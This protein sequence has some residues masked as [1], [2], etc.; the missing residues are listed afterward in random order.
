MLSIGFYTL[1]EGGGSTANAL[2]AASYIADGGNGA[3]VVLAEPKMASRPVFRNIDA[4]DRYRDG[5]TIFPDWEPGADIGDADVVIYDYGMVGTGFHFPDLDRIFMCSDS[6]DESIELLEGYK[7]DGCSGQYTL[8]LK[9][10]CPHEQ[11]RKF[12]EKHS[13]TYVVEPKT[14]T[15]PIV[16]KELLDMLL[17]Q[18]G[19]KRPGGN[20][21]ICTDDWDM[22]YHETEEETAAQ[23][24]SSSGIF[25]VL[26]Q[27]ASVLT[28]LVKKKNQE[29]PIPKE[30][31]QQDQEKT[32]FMGKLF[33]K[34]KDG[35]TAA[36][37]KTPEKAK[38]LPAAIPEDKDSG[39]ADG[40]TLDDKAAEAKLTKEEKEE[41]ARLAAEKKAEAERLK[42][43]RAE[44]A[45]AEAAEKKRLAEE[46]KKRAKEGANWKK[47]L[48]QMD[49][50]KAQQQAKAEEEQRKKEAERL[51][52]EEAEQRKAA[53]LEKQRLAEEKQAQLEE[54]KKLSEQQKAEDAA[55]RAEELRLKKE[56]LEAARAAE[57]AKKALEEEDRRRKRE[58][59]QAEKARQAEEARL[60]REEAARKAAE[61]AAEKK[62]ARE[63]E[64]ERK[65]AEAAEKKAQAELKKKEE[66]ERRIRLIEEK[67]AEAAARQAELD[68]QREAEAAEKAA[69]EEAER[70][71]IELK[72]MEDEARRKEELEQ[73]KAEAEAKRREDIERKRREAEAAAAVK[74]AERE[75]KAA[76]AEKKRLDAEAERALARE[77]K[78]AEIEERRLRAEQKKIEAEAR[79]AEEERRKAEEAE[80]AAAEA[81]VRRLE[82]EA[83]EA[84]K[85]AEREASS[86]A[87]IP[88]DDESISVSYINDIS[89]AEEKPEKKSLFG[90]GFGGFIQ[91]P[92]TITGGASR[93]YLGHI[94]VF[95]TSLRHGCG[96]SYVAGSIASYFT[97]TGATA[98]LCHKP[99]T[100]FPEDR[101]MI[102]YTG[103]APYDDAFRAKAVVFDRGTFPELGRAELSE[104]KKADMKLLV[105]N[106]DE[107]D[108]ERLATFIH[109][110]EDAASGWL[111]VFNL[112]KSRKS[113]K[114]IEELMQDYRIV[115]LPLHDYGALP[116]DV[117][118]LW[119]K[120]AKRAQK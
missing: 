62:A 95:V 1:S 110:M 114:H 3:H 33:G 74:Q 25:S 40:K 47:K 69:R 87:I 66:E 77:R 102:E 7:P 118:S 27:G 63:Q 37:E 79:K 4:L 90:G 38:D 16:L 111:Y 45:K 71:A 85:A 94:T 5:V 117:Q 67:K 23:K 73:K 57:A 31:T 42:K 56:E 64:L 112:P 99:G 88:E 26:S 6:A 93:G 82:K 116:K 65:K 103:G 105:S 109:K 13:R 100:N 84:E 34:K 108:I 75:R 86:T 115:F 96:S 119:A 60:L 12:K 9:F 11:L 91:K 10:P 80:I 50:E 76:E 44:Q 46:Q 22:E 72:R 48:A 92:A 83:A 97:S 107:R 21:V 29:D 55:R 35:G 101:Y 70:T 17:A 51:K 49:K 120:E 19:M 58:S 106:D 24:G 53:I 18:E 61:E 36:D 54:A 8:L 68:A 30:E 28:G 14:S 81:E 52:A 59:E 32:S 39:L 98:C 78:L 104:L 15:C 113:R 89:P 43:E 2:W 41:R 20:H